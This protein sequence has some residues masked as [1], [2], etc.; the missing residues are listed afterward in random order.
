MKDCVAYL[1]LAFL[2]KLKRRKRS[3]KY[4]KALSKAL[5]EENGKQRKKNGSYKK[6]K[7]AKTVLKSAHKTARKMTK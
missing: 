1:L 2:L 3:N 7:S 5:V 6:G 4:S